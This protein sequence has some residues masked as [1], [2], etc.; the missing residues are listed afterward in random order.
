[1]LAGAGAFSDKFGIL[2]AVGF[3]VGASASA[4]AGYVGMIIAVRQ[5]PHST[6]GMRA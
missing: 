1:L 6:G 5:R 2:T 3:L 4:L